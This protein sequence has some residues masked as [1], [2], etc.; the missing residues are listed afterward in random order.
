MK[1]LSYPAVATR[2]RAKSKQQGALLLLSWLTLVAR[3]RRGEVR[4]FWI[5]E[6]YPVLFVSATRGGELG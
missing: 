2:R 4:W 1:K 5:W 3:G 6:A